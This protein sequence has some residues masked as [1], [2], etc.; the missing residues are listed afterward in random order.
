[1]NVFIFHS[2]LLKLEFRHFHFL[3]EKLRSRE[4]W[5]RFKNTLLPLSPY[6]FLTTDVDFP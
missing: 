2:T 3:H 1:M 6:L 4:V 5:L